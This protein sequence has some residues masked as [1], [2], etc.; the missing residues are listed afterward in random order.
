MHGLI[1]INTPSNR[2]SSLVVVVANPSSLIVLVAAYPRHA[3]CMKGGLYRS[4][5]GRVGMNPRLC[6][7][8]VAYLVVL[9][10][11]S[12]PVITSS[13]VQFTLVLLTASP[14]G[15]KNSTGL[16]MSLECSL[17]CGAA[18]GIDSLACFAAS[19]MFLQQVPSIN[20]YCGHL[21]VVSCY[22]MKRMTK[23]SWQHTEIGCWS[24]YLRD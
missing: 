3:V 16:A 11:P 5:E 7:W 19:P 21:I 9:D 15:S 14:F 10:Y 23:I 12:K 22:I 17:S 18:V 20:N 24:T 4:G 13:G 1:V 6:R 8:L 2:T